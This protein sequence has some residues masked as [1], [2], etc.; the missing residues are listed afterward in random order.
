MARLS[1][2]YLARSACQVL[3]R[4]LV[5]VAAT[6]LLW[7][8]FFTYDATV[9]RCRFTSTRSTLLNALQ[10]LPYLRNLEVYIFETDRQ[11]AS[12]LMV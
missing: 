9:Y 4:D 12:G 3:A 10:V 6:K 11:V 8:S 5:V 2:G 1:A 7:G